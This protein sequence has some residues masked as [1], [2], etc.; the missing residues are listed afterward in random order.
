MTTSIWF[1]PYTVEMLQSLFGDQ[2]IGTTLDIK[3]VDIGSDYLKATMPVDERTKQP[4]GLLHGGV[5]CV[6]SESL[7]STAAWM[8]ID[9]ERFTAVG[10]EINANHLREVKQGTITGIC[11]PI[12]RGRSTHVWQTDIYDDQQRHICVS[13]HTVLIKEK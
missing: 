11:K 6:L 13:R 3:L 2:H 10:I 9:P 7:G 8:C 5:S 12:H 4:F 1:H